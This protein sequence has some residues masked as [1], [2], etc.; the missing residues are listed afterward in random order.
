MRSHSEIGSVVYDMG[1]GR[2]SFADLTVID[3]ISVETLVFDGIVSSIVG[4]STSDIIDSAEGNSTVWAGEGEDTIYSHAPAD[5]T[6]Y[7]VIHGGGGGDH[8][9]LL[10]ASVAF[11]D[12]GRDYI[13]GS[14]N[15]DRI[16]GGAGDDDI[17]AN[18][19]N[20]VIEGLS[21]TDMVSG[22]NGT[23]TY[24]VAG[25]NESVRF[26]LGGT[27]IQVT[28]GNNFAT[29]RADVERY[30]FIDTSSYTGDFS[31]DYADAY[32]LL[33][34]RS[35]HAYTASELRTALASLDRLQSYGTPGRN[36]IT[37]QGGPGSE[38]FDVNE[39]VRLVD[40]GGGQDVY[41]ITS[42]NYSIT[43]DFRS[44][45]T[46]SQGRK[47]YWIEYEGSGRTF[48]ADTDPSHYHVLARTSTLIFGEEMD[49]VESGPGGSTVY[50]GG[51]RDIIHGNAGT[52]PNFLYGEGGDDVIS[53][54]SASWAFGGVGEDVITGSEG[55]D[56][57]DGGDNNDRI[58]AAGGNDEIFGGKGNDRIN[59]GEG[60]DTA[61]YELD[62]RLVFYAKDGNVT[63]IGITRSSG[64][65]VEY[66]RLTSIERINIDGQ[67]IDLSTAPDGTVKAKGFDDAFVTSAL[68]NI[69]AFSI[70]GNAFDSAP[71]S[72]LILDLDGD[73]VEVSN[74][75]A[76]ITMFDMNLDGF[77][78]RTAWVRP[79]DALLAL[80]R[81]G[82]GIIDDSSE[83][84]GSNTTNGF[85]T[86]AALDSNQD[87]SITSADARFSELSLWRDANSDGKTDAGEI[88][89]LSNSDIASIALAAT[90][91]NEVNA[92]NPVT[93]RSIF[94]KAD[95]T[96]G[97]ID[98]VWFKPQLEF[99]KDKAIDGWT[100]SA[101]VVA[102]PTLVN[103]GTAH[104][105]MWS[106]EQDAGLKVKA[107]ALM[108]T[109]RVGDMT[110]FRKDFQLFI[111]DWLDVDPT[112][113]K[114]GYGQYVERSHY[115]VLTKLHGGPMPTTGGGDYLGGAASNLLEEEYQHAIDSMAAKFLAQTNTV[116]FLNEQGT[117]PLLEAFGG[118][119]FS[120]RNDSLIGDIHAAAKA[121]GAATATSGG[122]Q[123]G[124]ALHMLV[125]TLAINDPLRSVLAGEAL[126]AAAEAPAI[127][128]E[129]LKGYGLARTIIN[130]DTVET[131][132]TGH[133]NN[134]VR[135]GAGNDTLWS[136][137]GTNVLDPGAG[138]DTVS[139]QDGNDVMVY[140]RGYGVDSFNSMVSYSFIGS[141]RI[142]FAS[143]I[144][145]TDAT[146]TG[147]ADHVS[148]R[149]NIGQDDAI[150]LYNVLNTGSKSVI[151]EY[152]DG[153]KVS[154]DDLLAARVAA[155][156]GDDFITGAWAND[157]LD[158]GAGND[159]IYGNNGN[160]TLKGGEGDDL[161]NGEAGT[162]RLI[163][164]KG[165]DTHIISGSSVGIY[166][167]TVF[168]E[169]GDGNDRINTGNTA[170]FGYY[171][172]LELGA[173][174]G[175]ADVIFRQV[176]N[177]TSTDLLLDF[178]DGGSVTI[179][180][181]LTYNYRLGEIRFSD[182]SRM[183]EL[184]IV[185]AAIAG[186]DGDDYITIPYNFTTIPVNGMGGND[187]IV[188][189]TSNDTIN[190][191]TGND[192]I[193]GHAGNDTITGGSGDDV[194]NGGGGNDIIIYNLGDGNDTIQNLSTYYIYSNYAAG[195]DLLQLGAGIISTDLKFSQNSSGELVLTIGS[196]GT[197]A[198]SVTMLGALKTPALFSGFKLDDG[199]VI[200]MAD[201][202]KGTMTGTSGN[203][204][205]WGSGGADTI[206]G[207]QGDDILKGREG[208][209]TYVYSRGDGDDI[210]DETDN[211]QGTD[212]LLFS[213][214]IIRSDVRFLGGDSPFSVK[215]VI[216]GGGSVTI[217][218]GQR[219]YGYNLEQFKFADGTIV[220]ID[221]ASALA[222]TV[223]TGDDVL[224]G[225][226]SSTAWSY[227]G[228]DS[229]SGADGNDR[230][231]GGGGSDSLLGGN[232]NDFLDGDGVPAYT[233]GT[234][235]LRGDAGDDTLVYDHI[236]NLYGDAGQDVLDFRNYAS[237][238]VRMDLSAASQLVSFIAG[239][240]SGT[241]TVY[242]LEGA[243]FGAGDDVFVGNADAN[244]VSGGAGNDIMN[245]GDGA[246]A[247]QGG[248]G[249][250][251]MNGGA[252]N[253]MITI[254][255]S[256]I[257]DGGTG[258]DTL[259]ID[260]TIASGTIV[261]LRS[262]NQTM[263]VR[264][265]S[266][267]AALSNFESATLG[268]FDDVF[269]GN[270]NINVV[271]GNAGSDRLYGYGGAD[272]LNGGDG[273]DVLDGGDGNDTIAGGVGADTLIGGAGNDI[274]YTNTNTYA[275]DFPQ[276]ADAVDAGDGDDVIYVGSLGSSGTGGAGNDTLTVMTPVFTPVIVYVNGGPSMQIGMSPTTVLQ[277]WTGIEKFSLLSRDG[278]GRLSY[279]GYS[280]V[281]IASGST[282]ADVL[283]GYAGNDS[284]SGGA[285]KDTLDGG[286]GNDTLQGGAGNDTIVG[287]A[288]SDIAVFEQVRSN[289]SLT[290]S[291]SGVVTITELSTGYVDT[292]SG[293]EY[294][295][296]SEGTVTGIQSPVVLDLNG[297]GIHF[298]GQ[299]NGVMFDMD[300]DGM[301]DLTNWMSRGDAVL[302]LDR[303]GDG[304]VTDGSEMSFAA[305]SAGAATDMQ[306]LELLDLDGNGQI[307][308]LDPIY[309]SLR[310]WADDGDGISQT[311]EMLTLEQAGIRSIQLTTTA[312][313][314][315]FSLGDTLVFG[316]G[317][318]SHQ[319][320]SSGSLA[321]A[322]F[323]YS[324]GQSGAPADAAKLEA[325]NILPSQ[326]L[327]SA[328]VDAW[329]PSA[330][331]MSFHSAAFWPMIHTDLFLA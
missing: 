311:G 225:D 56:H 300:A 114:T 318:F 200:S 120:Y 268:A 171:G 214:G 313:S 108:A 9:H 234:D 215:A 261:D 126:A 323:S 289:Y 230:I 164:G 19:G 167:D 291:S 198:G 35:G 146:Y 96:T 302:V 58:S 216:A 123:A 257:A 165:N 45:Q 293:I 256:D 231:Y 222:R 327:N 63:T 269:H 101:S 320:G 211:Q 8:I 31:F 55:A 292:L 251:V 201:A 262:T 2:L 186:H 77:A 44:I 104:N 82:N 267:V 64:G 245:G 98:D 141:D 299:Q 76:S 304:I 179:T 159:Q 176:A 187:K 283:Y 180:N 331:E 81:N 61:F 157:V 40:G 112:P 43:I 129:I 205:I 243:I 259:L 295:R 42:D 10:G 113:G 59:G 314:D 67:D 20:D 220:T 277:N 326:A 148:I 250:D 189:N 78:E 284:L 209:D 74:V 288:G 156:N 307:D 158:G 181:G 4:T 3:L 66:D 166:A 71:Y 260:P 153:V 308:S 103:Y 133:L 244:L 11:G 309:D 275:F 136:G 33:L 249:N 127:E 111:M 274:I 217:Q 271:L 131:A 105:L 128:R 177:G 160:D 287:G 241:R 68:K 121:L 94:T 62:A 14:S 17:H 53:M 226:N 175:R 317:S 330:S 139:S 80:D 95:G 324:P 151:L 170:N 188:G 329:Q 7:N 252:G 36:F 102:M 235:T 248:A 49:V 21:G 142:V 319:D 224:W 65:T 18:G 173:G 34:A 75:T 281:D 117:S 183:S 110:Q 154:V 273:A 119:A 1:L 242:T 297:D 306:G 89:S 47:G 184:E 12:A 285:G 118:M 39:D 286:D 150:I 124:I 208:G 106:M 86:L 305:E 163:G 190:G 282:G 197:N 37:I 246:D 93:H 109:A 227:L 278:L 41:F 125:D 16:N 312:V 199:T 276:D 239:G 223:T 321:D 296:T 92:G 168:Y 174:I 213:T 15:D 29:V 13:D 46:D 144:K 69:P 138:N 57:I 228:N 169:I 60:S 51:G 202:I 301:L 207:G 204:T 266:E 219:Q 70:P 143:D 152:G 221:Q 192:D 87:G 132:L 265:S 238:S 172:A 155:T 25:A 218:L 178:A 134:V 303:N 236:D 147:V 23:D 6:E 130:M 28:D 232:G 91:I 298:T 212:T 48:I 54:D 137:T 210:I 279:A 270:E 193:D 255:G 52:T 32:F 107:D 85:V 145:S 73:G 79:D 294:M 310:L 290:T 325:E 122:H 27:D 237:A 185:T 100:P 22:G 97:R 83:L 229:L 280:G 140:R 38:T 328:T 72:P 258:I 115:M 315:V 149:V 264:S 233:F 116:A 272:N 24:I 194:I 26:I 196:D 263:T 240:P 161:L 322:A 5:G 191:G 88:T 253:D 254:D 84:F 30:S 50:A 135:G 206:N 182:G 162:D 99:S 316:S 195:V 203:D 247:L 90:T